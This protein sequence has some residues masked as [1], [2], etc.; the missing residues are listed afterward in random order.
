MGGSDCGGGVIGSK[1]YGDGAEGHGDF[2]DACEVGGKGDARPR[3]AEKAQAVS[4]AW[5]ADG[6]V[7]ALKPAVNLRPAPPRARA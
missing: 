1:T 6:V 4:M 5:R 2:W 7:G 3:L